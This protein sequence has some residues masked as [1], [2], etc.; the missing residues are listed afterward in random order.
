MR[1]VMEGSGRELAG[2]V[3]LAD[4]LFL[5]MKGLLGR[6]SLE[7]GHC[8]WIRPCKGVHTFFMR[9]AIDVIFLDRQQRVVELACNLAPNRM[10]PVYGKA[11]SVLELPAHAA[12]GV[13]FIGDV[14]MF[15]Q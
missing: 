6:E 15:V 13:V 8:L 7:Q 12:E 2:H 3:L 14:V 9:F 4:S 1:A 10:T 11:A 5:R